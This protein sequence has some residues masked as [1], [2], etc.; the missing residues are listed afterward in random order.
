[1]EAV[2]WD[3]DP[4]RVAVADFAIREQAQHRT[5][6]MLP[7]EQVRTRDFPMQGI[8]MEELSTGVIL[9]VRASEQDGAAFRGAE[10]EDAPLA[11]AEAAGAGKKQAHSRAVFLNSNRK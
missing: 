7:T 6:P 10:E 8:R 5:V 9:M 3:R 1:M 4:E 11:A 2:R